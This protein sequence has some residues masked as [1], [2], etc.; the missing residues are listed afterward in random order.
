[1]AV[2]LTALAHRLVLAGHD[3]WTA[4]LHGNDTVTD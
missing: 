1:L 3:R 2:I 4:G